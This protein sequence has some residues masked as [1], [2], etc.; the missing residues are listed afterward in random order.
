MTIYKAK[1]DGS[2]EKVKDWL[3]DQ[4]DLAEK[5]DKH[6]AAEKEFLDSL[7]KPLNK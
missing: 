7:E 3:E 2:I 6:K 4:E 5:Y 1:S